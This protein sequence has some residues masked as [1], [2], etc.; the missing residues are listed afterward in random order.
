[1]IKAVTVLKNEKAVAIYGEKGKNDVII[2]QT[3]NKKKRKK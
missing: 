3:K 1:M 2:I